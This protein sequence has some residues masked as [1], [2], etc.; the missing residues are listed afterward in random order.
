MR[1]K[2][3]SIL[4]LMSLL[5]LFSSTSLV[6]EVNAI[7]PTNKVEN[8]KSDS[9]NINNDAD[10]MAATKKK[11]QE[12]IDNKSRATRSESSESKRT[13]DSIDLL[14]TELNKLKKD[15]EGLKETAEL[16]GYFLYAFC[17]VCL[18][19]IGGLLYLI[20][21]VRS[22]KKRKE[23]RGSHS[24][25]STDIDKYREKQ[26]K[27]SKQTETAFEGGDSNV[28][29][30]SLETEV[31]KLRNEIIGLQESIK[32][33]D[34]ENYELRQ[35]QQEEEQVQET[36]PGPSNP[37]H[38]QSMT[39]YIDGAPSS[40]RGNLSKDKSGKSCF[41]VMSDGRFDLSSGLTLD[42]KDWL[43]SKL[44]DIKEIVKK[45]GAGSKIEDTYP[46]MLR[47][48]LNAMKWELISPITIKL[49][50]L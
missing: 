46:G 9:T 14:Q 1:K 29:I 37:I 21:T 47:L 16:Q 43:V 48:D 30:K 32:R 19:L 50:E 28:R 44:D 10:T 42:Q 34:R 45:E 39:Y 27:S 40:N 4:T 33:S 31:N 36:I 8:K 26:Q 17:V 7:E 20:K 6:A 3:T 13:E 22:L 12:A 23:R 18:F 35:R 2:I 41:E 25:Q 11:E 24:S 49:V 15:L 5:L 38:V